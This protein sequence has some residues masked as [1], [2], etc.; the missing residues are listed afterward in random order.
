MISSTRSRCTSS[1]RT[2]LGRKNMP[3]KIPVFPCR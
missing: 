3:L 2:E 1:S